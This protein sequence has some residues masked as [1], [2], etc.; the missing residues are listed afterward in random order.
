NS[1]IEKAQSIGAEQVAGR[2]RSNLALALVR[3]NRASEALD[4]GKIAVRK[5]LENSDFYVLWRARANVARAYSLLGEN[6]NADSAFRETLSDFENLRRT[7]TTERDRAE[8]KRNLQN[9]Q[10]EFISFTLETR[11]VETAFARLARSKSRALIELMPGSE[12][13][14]ELSD[15]AL[16]GSI[17]SELGKR[18]KTILLDFFAHENKLKAFAC[19][20]EKITVHDIKLPLSRIERLIDDLSGEINLFIASE[21]Y[22]DAQ[23]E[24]E[25]SPPESL[26]KLGDALI[27]PVM[28]RIS[29]F[30]SILFVPH[31][32]L[33]HVPF[34]ALVVND[35]N[36]LV[37]TQSIS[38]MP[39]SD[40][41]LY[42]KPCSFNDSVKIAALIGSTDGIAQTESELESLEKIFG[43]N[44]IRVDADEILEKKDH[45]KQERIIESAD[46]VHFIGHAEFDPYDP[47][48][49]ALILP[50]NRRLNVSDFHRHGINLSDVK[51]VTLSACETGRGKV[52]TGDEVIGIARGFMLAGAGCA[53]VS[54]WKVS[55]KAS[56]KMMPLFYSALINGKSPS[57]ALSE[58]IREML[59]SRTHPYFFAP[60]QLISVD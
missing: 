52:L 3:A 39:S 21:Q 6:E 46:I 15:D 11:G 8:F 29:G 9:L 12:K 34:H 54:L 23:W 57:D 37:E 10:G 5:A 53:L 27:D 22:R 48:S 38:L 19:C 30:E 55:D 16:S 42:R 47:Y 60:F 32:V 59:K 2:T 41:L 36:Y 28:K 20:P 7:L 25:A 44:F 24:K 13:I 26:Q 17:K 56:A 51:L 45:D 49:S 58:A 18:K 50:G 4:A 31:D 43:E 40:F 33:H 14:D 1:L 35:K